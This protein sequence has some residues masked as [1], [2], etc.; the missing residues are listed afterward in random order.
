M[1]TRFRCLIIVT[2]C[3]C[4]DAPRQRTC[5]AGS[6]VRWLLFAARRQVDSHLG[7]CTTAATLWW[8]PTATRQRRLIWT[9]GTI[10]HMLLRQNSIL[11][12]PLRVVAA[13][14]EDGSSLISIV[15]TVTHCGADQ[16]RRLV[17]PTRKRHKVNRKCSLC[18]SLLAARRRFSDHMLSE[19]I[20]PVAFYTNL[21]FIKQM[22][23]QREIDR[24]KSN[25]HT[26]TK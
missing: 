22:V 21:L 16:D 1:A 7:R 20:K 8:R 18:N 4:Y 3:N 17:Q 10:A 19:R 11:T 2:S 6:R 25:K 15:S 23:A 9:D 12:W 24:V 5:S 26:H 13:L 14:P